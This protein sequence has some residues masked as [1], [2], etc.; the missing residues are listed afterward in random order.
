MFKILSH[1]V[2]LA[3]FSEA[4][5][6]SLIARNRNQ[7]QGRALRHHS[8]VG[9]AAEPATITLTL[10]PGFWLPLT[11]KTVHGS[12]QA[13]GYQLSPLRGWGSGAGNLSTV[14]V[15]SELGSPENH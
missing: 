9:L 15:D 12:G 14:T 11:V 3:N 1:R 5:T 2:K 4:A 8:D 13:L 10:S 6:Q 7:A